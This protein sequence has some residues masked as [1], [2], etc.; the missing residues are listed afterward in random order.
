MWP[1]ADIL[2]GFEGWL[3]SGALVMRFEDLVGSSGGGDD[4]RQRAALRSMYDFLG[5]D[6]DQRFIESVGNRLFSS[7]SP[8]F[9][10]GTIGAWRQQFD[11]EV[12]EEF[13]RTAG[14]LVERFGYR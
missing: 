1:I 13:E 10:R 8:T 9:R 7:R 11:P 2:S 3:D 4:I 12:E 6:V 5:L 14:A